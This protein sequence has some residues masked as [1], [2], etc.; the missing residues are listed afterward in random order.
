MRRVFETDWLGSRPVFYNE[1]SAEVSHNVNDVIDFSNLEFDPEGLRNYLSFGY[2][3]LG[4]TPVKNVKFLRHSSRLTVDCGRL[5]IESLGDPVDQWLGTTSH[6]D[7][8]FHMLHSSVR[9]WERSV[10]GEI[11]IPTSGGF[12][13]RLLN[14]L[15]EDKT[16][17]RSFT[18][19]LSKVQKKSREVVYAREIAKILSTRWDWIPLGDFNIYFDDWIKLFGVSTHAHGM[20]H[21]EFYSKIRKRVD[22]GNPLLSGII[23]D[24]WSGNVRI[25]EIRCPEDVIQIGYTHGLIA[26]ADKC[27]L[28]SRQDALEGYFDQMREKLK[29]PVFVIVEAMRFK[30]ILL[31]YLL[32][33]PQAFGFRSW[34]PFLNLDI[35][36][37]MLT[38]PPGRKID[39]D[40]QVQIFRR[41]G[42]SVEDMGLR[43]DTSNVL[44]LEG[45]RRQPLTPLDVALL[46]EVIDPAYVEWINRTVCRARPK[47][48]KWRVG[49]WLGRWRLEESDQIWSAYNAYLVLKPIE[50]LIKKRNAQVRGV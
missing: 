21:I 6:E 7:D 24:A 27:L 2:S 13:S 19:G 20:Y 30:L 39:R 29:S 17:I 48:R 38:L 15:V 44:D 5:E 28:L 42:V 31:S 12:D 8:V 1:T 45:M 23:G 46:R 18:Y 40:W 16:R 25:P 32:I 9:D 36:L 14:L 49:A 33:V 26:D 41:Y 4:Q 47:S 3:V 37:S 50:A 34:S 22:G 43:V 11:I 35:A 10:E